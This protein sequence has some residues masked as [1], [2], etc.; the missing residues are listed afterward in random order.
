M[1]LFLQKLEVVFL[2]EQVCS[3]CS[4]IFADMIYQIWCQKSKK[5]KPW[6][7]Q[8]LVWYLYGTNTNK[9]MPSALD[10]NNRIIES[11][12]EGIDIPCVANNTLEII[13][14]LKAKHDTD[15]FCS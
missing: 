6:W 14:Y 10:I 12:Y 3:K 15:C 5:G 13:A 11:P 8:I 7:T 1:Q 9:S 4:G 2:K